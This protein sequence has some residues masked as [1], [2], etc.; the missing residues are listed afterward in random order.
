[1]VTGHLDCGDYALSWLPN[2]IRIER[3][4]LPDLLGCVGRQRK[5]FDAEMNRMLAFPCRMLIVEASWGQ[6]TQGV[7]GA[8]QLHSSQVQGSLDAWQAR[9]VNVVLAGD[10]SRAQEYAKRILYAA[11]KSNWKRL[12]EMASAVLQR[13]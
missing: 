13:C 11:V 6:I 3:K 7:Y 9:G 1:M 8:S 5:R 10:R 4:S 2:A 12:R